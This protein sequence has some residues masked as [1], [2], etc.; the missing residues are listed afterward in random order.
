[1]TILPTPRAAARIS[2]FLDGH[3]CW[4]AFWDKKSQVRRVTEDDPDADLYAESRDADTV[5]R[6]MNAHS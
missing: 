5:I 2:A 3:P 1:M 4:T 6:Y